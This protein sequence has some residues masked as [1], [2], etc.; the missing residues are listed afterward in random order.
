MQ[1]LVTL[2]NKI[3]HRSNMYIQEIDHLLMRQEN[4]GIQHDCDN[5][6]KIVA[7]LAVGGRKITELLQVKRLRF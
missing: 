2:V 4:Y 1:S 7:I 5:F 6:S 3:G